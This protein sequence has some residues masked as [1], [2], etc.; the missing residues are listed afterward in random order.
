M[1]D[2]QWEHYDRDLDW[3]TGPFEVYEE[4]ENGELVAIPI[5]PHL[6]GLHSAAVHNVRERHR[7]YREA[8]HQFR[9]GR[10]P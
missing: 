9:R 7:H 10:K 5:M 4:D 2:N 8:W 1:N 3:P 6:G